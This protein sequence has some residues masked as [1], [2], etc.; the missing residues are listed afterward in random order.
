M[1]LLELRPIH[2]NKA[3]NAA[4]IIAHVMYVISNPNI[5]RAPGDAA[6]DCLLRPAGTDLADRS[7][8]LPVLSSCAGLGQ[9]S[10]LEPRQQRTGIPI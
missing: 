10:T 3:P 5:G 2:R 9:E 7:K 1:S 6:P 4:A 8:S